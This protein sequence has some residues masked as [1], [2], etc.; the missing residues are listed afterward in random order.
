M[1]KFLSAT[2]MLFCSVQSVTAGTAMEA[3]LAHP[4]LG[5]FGTQ[6]DVSEATS[7]ARCWWDIAIRLEAN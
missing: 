3:R 1:I 4:N 2:V 5:S 7:T 6:H